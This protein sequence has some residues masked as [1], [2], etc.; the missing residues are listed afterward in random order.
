MCAAVGVADMHVRYVNR[1][2]LG[3]IEATNAARGHIDTYIQTFPATWDVV[4]INV[5]LAQA[6]PN[7]FMHYKDIVCMHAIIILDIWLQIPICCFPS[8]LRSHL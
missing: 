2:V 8:V 4:M 1:R 7:K 3:N 5:G 6:R